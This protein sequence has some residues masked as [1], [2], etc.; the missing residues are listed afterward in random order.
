MH[1]LPR[2][3]ARPFLSSLR[4]AKRFLFMGA[5]TWCVFFL[6]EQQEGELCHLALPLEDVQWH[7]HLMPKREG[8]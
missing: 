1:T 2:P 6:P 8:D 7:N 4:L 5:A 3:R